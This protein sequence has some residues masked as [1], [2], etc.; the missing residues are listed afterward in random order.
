MT[1]PALTCVV[2]DDHPA[3]LDSLSRVLEGHGIT[4]VARV[5]DGE[6]AIQAIDEHQ[7]VVAVIDLRMPGLSGMAVARRVADRT[8]VILYTGYSDGSLVAEA[9]DA[10]VKGF[11]LKEAPLGDVARAIQTVGGGGI[12]V[13]P[14]LAG[15]LAA[16]ETNGS[17][18][19]LSQREREVLR[20]LADGLR[21]EEIGHRLHI[22]AETARA[23]I[24]NAM[25]KLGAA[26]RTQAVALALRQSMIE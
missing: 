2:A 3:V 17:L 16:A 21:N 19:L 22:A 5:R 18:K 20:L 13:D 12:Y 26:T 25:R 4:V 7:P 24:R 1:A 10:G 9:L 11:V 23:H 14:V 15:A 6:D 8:R